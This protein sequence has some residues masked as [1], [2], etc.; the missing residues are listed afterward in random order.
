MQLSISFHY[1]FLP[2][3]VIAF[4]AWLTPILTASLRI[5]K[6][7]TVIIEIILG[8]LISL[9]FKD[10]FDTR[11]LEILNFLALSGFIFL[12]FLSGLEID[13]DTIMA[14]LPRYGLSW[15]SFLKNPLLSG[16]LHFILVILLSFL[17]THIL[18]FFVYIPSKIYYSL[19]LI[20]T[21]V[22]IVFPVLKNR[23]EL[24]SRFGQ[25]V[26]TTA[27]LADIFSIIIFTFT[28]IILSKGFIWQ[29]ILIPALFLFFYVLNKAGKYAVKNPLF[30][31]LDFR[32]SGSALQVNMRGALL[33]ILIF[34]VLSQYIGEEVILLGAFLSGLLLSGFTHKERSLLLVKL[35]G[36]GFGFFIPVFFIMVGFQ[37]E[38]EALKEFDTGIWV[39]L[40]LLT[41]FLFLIKIIPS[42]LFVPSFGLKRAIGAGFL[43]SARLSLIIAAAA[44]GLKNGFITEGINSSFVLMAVITSLVAPFG[45]EWFHPRPE[46][47]RQKIIIVGGS[48]TA[49]LLARRLNFH[50]KKVVII[51]K[52]PKRAEEIRQKGIDV[53][54]ADATNPNTF[55]NLN[56]IPSNAV[57]LETGSGKRNIR[58]AQLLRDYYSHE[59][60]FARTRLREVEDKLRHFNVKVADERRI[61][62]STIENL[63]F[64][65]ATY[66]DLIESYENFR[67]EE[68]TVPPSGLKESMIRK[69]PWPANALL[70]L[71]RREGNYLIPHGNNH[72]YPGDLLYI[73]GT[74]EAIENV[75][76]MF[77]Q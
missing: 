3:L 33:I 34:V 59:N 49:V 68:I 72:I 23:G 76:K 30:K 51:E 53:I 11:D 43:L 62:A 31:K 15:S 57:V 58:I 36:M 66:N 60:I 26:I 73:F 64:R 18:S 13:V 77:I 38:T 75:K 32:F 50:D 46:I 48:S 6:V 69:I 41:L 21:S 24:R 14:S 25:M 27:A 71:I 44:I 10:R 56:L 28:A 35:D 19:I 67:L 8:F 7:P 2:I 4:I 39:Y 12:M 65:P 5:R 17:A 42:L 20:T 61:M 55:K 45:F 40:L 29:L 22:G 16:I 9:Y 47:P 1:D 37:F 70:I 54:E 52:N 74:D 63:L